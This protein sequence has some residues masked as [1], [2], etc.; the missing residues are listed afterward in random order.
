VLALVVALA[1]AGSLWALRAGQEPQAVA[2]GAGALLAFLA[3]WLLVLGALL[4]PGR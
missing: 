1:A 3:L 4:G 2:L